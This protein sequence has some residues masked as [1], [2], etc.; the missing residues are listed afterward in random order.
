[1]KSQERN[2]DGAPG[3]LAQLVKCLDLISA[4]IMISLFVE[5]EP[6]VRLYA[7]PEPAW[8]SLSLSAPALST[9]SLKQLN[10]LEKKKKRNQEGT[11]DQ[12]A[13]TFLG[14]RQSM[15]GL[16]TGK[17]FK[18]ENQNGTTYPGAGWQ[19]PGMGLWNLG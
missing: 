3:W 17:A 6:H 1:M 19:G 8:D 2:R 15:E 12:K 13:G 18:T 7:G 4:Q 16:G 11:M 9:F 5:F 14:V 10:K